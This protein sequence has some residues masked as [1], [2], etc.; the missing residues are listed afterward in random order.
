MKTENYYDDDDGFLLGL[1]PGDGACAFEKDGSV[2]VVVAVVVEYSVEWVPV[3]T[4]KN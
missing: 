1:C 2:A 3:A 4:T